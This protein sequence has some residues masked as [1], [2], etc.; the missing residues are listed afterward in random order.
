MTQFADTLWDLLGLTNHQRRR[1]A[2]RQGGAPRPG[3]GRPR[4]PMQQRYDALVDQM[5]QTYGVRVRKW[6]SSS[7]GCAWLVRY[8]DGTESKLIEAPYPK[9]PISCA[10][11]LHEIAHHAI[12]FGRHRLRC[13]EEYEAWRW[14]LDVMRAQRLN[15]TPAVHERITESLRY[16]VRKARK[17]GLKMLPDELR[18]YV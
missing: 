4:R 18:P 12:G 13:M 6:R 11:F 3:A 16:A 1:K 10:I 7:T 15:V 8:A 9:G 5:K 2:T 17:R 14:A